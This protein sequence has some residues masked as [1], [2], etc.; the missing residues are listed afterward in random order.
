LPA[1]AAAARSVPAARRRSLAVISG[2][3]RGFGP[4]LQRIGLCVASIPYGIAVR[5]R[6]L[7]YD[8]GWA[9]TSRVAATVVSVG[10]LTVGGTGKT[11]FVEHVA[12]YYRRRDVRVA[13]L[14]R[15]Y[16][17]EG[18]PNDEALLLEENL[19]DV[20]HL[21]GADRVA[22]AKAAIEELESELLV[23][24]DGF[25]HRRLFRD[26]DLVLID[27]T[28]PWGHGRLLPRGLLREPRIGLRRAHLVA[29]TRCDQASAAAKARL[30]EEIAR[31]APGVTVIETTHRPAGLVNSDG[32]AA[33]LESLRGRPAAAFCGIG[34]P[35]SFR[36]TLADL[37]ADLRAFR[38]YP[39]HH[40][41]T[42]EDVDDV[43]GWARGLPA[44]C[45][46]IVTQKDMVKL[47]LSRLG[48]RPLWSLRVRLQVEAGADELESRLEA[49]LGRRG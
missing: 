33:P 4:S 9:R 22:L 14:S 13:V 26:L 29:L 17:A 15:G 1:P 21:Q 38:T 18:A 41:Y 34:N 45:Q 16:G 28:R 7:G 2:E 37:G 12:G 10:N 31:L 20:P 49:A 30:R 11:P 40:A 6:N 46:V 43:G 5:F 44:D 3:A 27:A 8:R 42:R 36:R 23:L 48:G 47:R 39:D 25:Q 32:E 24:D 19:P 35:D